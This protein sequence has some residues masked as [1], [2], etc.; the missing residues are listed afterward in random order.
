MLQKNTMTCVSS[1]GG[2]AIDLRIGG[3]DEWAEPG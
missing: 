2:R 3:F 1:G